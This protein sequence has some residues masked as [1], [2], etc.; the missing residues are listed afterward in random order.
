M[1]KQ[2]QIKEE[3]LEKEKH[4]KD[5]SVVDQSDSNY[6][7]HSKPQSERASTLNLEPPSEHVDVKKLLLHN[8]LDLHNLDL[9][10][11]PPINRVLQLSEVNLSA[12]PNCS[13]FLDPSLDYI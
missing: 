13:H 7:S 12:H 9:G 11:S 6:Q 1:N 8:P 10:G 5:S 3:N 2:E 4:N